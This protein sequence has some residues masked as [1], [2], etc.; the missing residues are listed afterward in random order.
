MDLICGDEAGGGLG[1][2]GFLAGGAGVGFFLVAEIFC[3]E[4]R[5]FL[6]IEA[7]SEHTLERH[8]GAMVSAAYQFACNFWSGRRDVGGLGGGARCALWWG[9]GALHP[10]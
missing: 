6:G 3:A 7:Y 9:R 5:F 4:A 8:V 10:C 2:G 1:E